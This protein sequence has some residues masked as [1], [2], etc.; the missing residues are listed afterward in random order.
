M[1][2]SVCDLVVFMAIIGFIKSS[3]VYDEISG[4]LLGVLPRF[5]PVKLVLLVGWVYLCLYFVQRVEFSELV[6]KKY[7]PVVNVLPLLTGPAV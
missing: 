3:A 2:F 7:K 5:S 6:P 1:F 4:G